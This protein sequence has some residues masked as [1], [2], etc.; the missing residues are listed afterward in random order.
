[1]LSI[2]VGNFR[3]RWTNFLKLRRIWT[4]EHNYFVGGTI[5]MMH[6]PNLAGALVKVF[7]IDTYGVYPN[8]PISS[9]VAIR[10]QG[11]QKI[12]PDLKDLTLVH[13]NLVLRFRK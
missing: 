7:L 9:L 6:T 3:N 13:D 1:M 12:L 2:I 4:Q 8:A 11:K 5:N 10:L